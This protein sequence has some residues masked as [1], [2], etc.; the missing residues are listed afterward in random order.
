[1]I[2]SENYVENVLRTAT[3]DFEAIKERLN[4]PEIIMLLHAAMGLDTEQAEFMDILKKYIYYGKSFD[5]VNAIEELGDSQWYLGL[6]VY[7][8]KTTINDILTGNIEKLKLRY[9]EGFT[10]KDAIYRHLGEE[11]ELL[12]K[13]GGTDW[14]E[15]KSG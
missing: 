2:T 15:L 4:N 11:R 12:E 7:A 6:A 13:I 10:E 1:M 8:L 5:K 14:Q 3:H 9:P